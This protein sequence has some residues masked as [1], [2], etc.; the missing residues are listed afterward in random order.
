M[1]TKCS[2]ELSLV[3]NPALNL[4]LFRRF[5]CPVRIEIA[6]RR[7]LDSRGVAP[8]VEVILRKEVASDDARAERC[9]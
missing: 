2:C 4:E 6:D 8:G 9:R 1:S 5:P 7:E 3:A